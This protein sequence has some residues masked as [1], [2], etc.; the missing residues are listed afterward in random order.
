M[1]NRLLK[2][3]DFGDNPQI[4]Q[5]ETLLDIEEAIEQ[6]RQEIINN[7]PEIPESKDYTEKLD[8][9][10]EK[11]NDEEIEITLNII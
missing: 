11:L 3:A 1:N 5:M 10:L 6:S 8:M 9:I 7:I 2:L 4:T